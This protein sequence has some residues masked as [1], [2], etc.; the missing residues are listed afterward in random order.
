VRTAW[1]DL[2]WP[3]ERAGEALRA[4]AR[5]SGLPVRDADV[6]TITVPAGADAAWLERAVVRLA[7]WLD[8]EAEPVGAAAGDVEALVR[9]AGPALV[10][11]PGG[12]P[13]LLALVPS[14]GRGLRVLDA[15]GRTHDA[16]AA[17]LRGLLCR[18]LEAPL[19][20]E[21]AAVLA[22]AGV[23]DRRREAATRALLAERLSGARVEG[24][25]MIRPRATSPLRTQLA[26][27]RMVTRAARLLG[28]HVLEQA[29]FVGSFWTLG[30]TALAGHVDVGWLTAWVLLVASQVP[31]RAYVAGAQAA[32]AIDVAAVL[33]RHLLAGAL[34]LDADV[35]R[36]DG[37][38]QMLGRVFESEAV[39]GLAIG[40]G[41]AALLACIEL[42]V[43]AVVLA[44]GAAP[45][46][47]LALL[48]GFV[49][50]AG[51][52]GAALARARGA[53]T[54]ERL[55][56]THDTIE[57][58]V[59][60]RTR[61]AQESPDAWHDG[62]DQAL[63]RLHD[64]GRRMD[65][66][67]TWLASALPRGW[68]V[69]SVVGLVPALLAGAR[70]TTAVAISVGGALL[71]QGALRRVSEGVSAL[72][73]AAV[74]L[75][76]LE[77]LRKAALRTEPLASPVALGVVA[78]DDPE[79]TV[80]EAR[81][82]GFQHQ[83]RLSPVLRDASLRLDARDRVLVEGPSG[84]GKSTLAAI[85][86]G[87]REPRGGLVLLDGLDRK[88]LGDAAWRARVAGVPQFHENHVLCA[89]LAFNLLMGRAWPPTARDLADAEAVCRD[90][91]LGPLLERMPGG[92]HQPVGET[93]WQLSHGERSRVYV[94]RALLQGA[95]VVVLDESFAA[96]DS[97]TLRRAVE[98][99]ASR[100]VAAVVIAHP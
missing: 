59:G 85:L 38:G 25:M 13:R 84:S 31:L 63:A 60:H 67:A 41:F 21:V 23:P 82:L 50:A 83:G 29:L 78:E 28:A 7:D 54:D 5:C 12:G 95:E 53:W 100:P 66:F 56:L 62:E 36:T 68:L 3:A 57:R 70:A 35:A 94:A 14:R 43:G 90:L 49:A 74:G 11:L 42:A 26:R 18:E 80:L 64:R 20:A 24:V 39:E 87:L 55:A 92:L 1:D 81:H 73:G 98:C 9:G 6:P 58:M 76:R 30:A 45:T 93:G 91:D 32:I 61:L 16:R 51:A 52:C 47:Q 75:R 69:A 96:L 71:V 33:K 89:S 22:A 19:L 34:R 86:T 46:V 15:R 40:G 79:R 2:A 48:V 4:A 8:V 72:A 77:P 37:A 27:A 17:D 97:A 10:L 99:V 65:R 88:T 44:F